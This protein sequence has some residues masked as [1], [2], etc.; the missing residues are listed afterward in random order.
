MDWDEGCCGKLNQVLLQY[1]RMQAGFHQALEGLEPA[2]KAGRVPQHLLEPT[3][4]RLR[5]GALSYH[6]AERRLSE[7]HDLVW[8]SVMNPRG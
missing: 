7:C 8:H 3:V 6:R 1:H 5:S 4:Q 2:V